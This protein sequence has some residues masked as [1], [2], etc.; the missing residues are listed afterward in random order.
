[1]PFQTLLGSLGRDAPE[2]EAVSVRNSRLRRMQVGAL[3]SILALHNPP[4]TSRSDH[5]QASKIKILFK[6]LGAGKFL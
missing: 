6:T 5:K 3:G 1:M 2:W 4:G